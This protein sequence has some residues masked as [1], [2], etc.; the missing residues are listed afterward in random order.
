MDRIEKVEELKERIVSAG[1]RYEVSKYLIGAILLDEAQR[2]NSIDKLQDFLARI[3]INYPN[4]IGSFFIYALEIIFLDKIEDQ[5]FGL[6][7][8]NVGTLIALKGYLNFKLEGNNKIELISKC[9]EILLTESL[10]P[11]LVS[12]MIRK[13][14]DHWN[15]QN[16]DIQNRTGICGTL[17]SIGIEGPKGIHNNPQPNKRGLK[18]K[19]MAEYL[20]K[21]KSI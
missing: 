1:T 21:T 15:D 4:L 6:S 10:A 19:E 9:L 13:T 8:M 3:V 5:S 12:A 11:E 16:I 20:E 14:I 2:F 7:Q 17:Y 18:I